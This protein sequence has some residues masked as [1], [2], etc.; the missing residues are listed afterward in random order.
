MKEI[1]Y[2]QI[3]KLYA[4]AKQKGI[5]NEELHELVYQCSGKDSIKKLTKDEGIRCIDR[6]EGRRTAPQGRIT[7]SQEAYLHDLI[8]RLGWQNNPKRLKG[9]IKKYA[10]VDEIKWLTVKQAS[11]VIEGL[12]RQ[13]KASEEAIAK[14]D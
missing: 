7:Q 2:P 11:N 4:L 9:F 12:K 1:T 5:D 8:K 10:K 3:K 14:A 6:I 13:V